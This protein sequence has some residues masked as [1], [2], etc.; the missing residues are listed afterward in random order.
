M[1]CVF[2]QET[3]SVID[4]FI[5]WNG[6]EW[7]KSIGVHIYFVFWPTLREINY[8]MWMVAVNYSLDGS[9]CYELVVHGSCTCPV[10][11]R[12]LRRYSCR[13]GF[14]FFLILLYSTFNIHNSTEPS[15][16][17]ALVYAARIECEICSIS[18]IQLNFS[19]FVAKKIMFPDKI[20]AKI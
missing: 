19:S 16:F 7:W 8:H 13:I 12:R 10:P 9:I 15:E 4:S 18:C 11:F 2:Q 3:P 20:V 1:W 6:T 14:S 5:I 17:Y